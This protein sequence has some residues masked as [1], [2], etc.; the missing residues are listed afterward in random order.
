ME[1]IPIFSDMLVRLDSMV[2]TG[3]INTGQASL[4]K[5]LALKRDIQTAE[6]F[7]QSRIKSDRELA[8]DLLPLLE[9]NRRYLVPS[10]FSFQVKS[11]SVY[12][13]C[14]IAELSQKRTFF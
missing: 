10:F 1:L 9:P 6:K 12:V 11:K 4:L 13:F 5:V 3:A 7:S 14:V 2:L 8:L